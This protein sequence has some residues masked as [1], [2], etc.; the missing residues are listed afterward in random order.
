[1]KSSTQRRRLSTC[2]R[3]ACR[4]WDRQRLLE[5]KWE[6]KIPYVELPE[7]S[8]IRAPKNLFVHT[9]SSFPSAHRAKFCVRVALPSPTPKCRNHTK[10]P[11]DPE[12]PNQSSAGKFSC[13]E[14]KITAATNSLPRSLNASHPASGPHAWPCSPCRATCSRHQCRPGSGSPRCRRHGASA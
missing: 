8:N 1:M 13:K 4:Q 6:K 7:L 12:S 2:L 3:L 9:S 10:A 11:D 14:K 5:S